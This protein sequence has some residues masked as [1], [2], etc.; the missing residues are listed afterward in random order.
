ML[1][2]GESAGNRRVTF[3]RRDVPG[4]SPAP[5][6]TR[7]PSDRQSTPNCLARQSLAAILDRPFGRGS[8]LD[9]LRSADILR[10]AFLAA[11]AVARFVS[12]RRRDSRKI[13]QRPCHDFDPRFDDVCLRCAGIRD[14]LLPDGRRPGCRPADRH[15]RPARRPAQVAGRADAPVGGRRRLSFAVGHDFHRPLGSALGR[16]SPAMTG[17]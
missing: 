11:R 4:S 15:A 8:R 13:A 12:P 17:S 5:D 3:Q 2:R 6:G 14:E 9:P 1:H 16:G 10:D 7:A